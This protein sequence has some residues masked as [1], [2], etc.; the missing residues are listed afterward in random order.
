MY[1]TVFEE[2]IC[3]LKLRNKIRN[4]IKINRVQNILSQHNL[5]V[6][7]INRK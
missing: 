4:K 5:V 2:T 3:S 6:Y 7:N 1:F